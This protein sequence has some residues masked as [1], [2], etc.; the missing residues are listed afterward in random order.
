MM[1]MTQLLI[2]RDNTKY[3]NMISQLKGDI[4]SRDVLR[5][6]M[7]SALITK[8]TILGI[9]YLPFQGLFGWLAGGWLAGQPPHGS[10]FT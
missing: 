7:L 8:E 3:A 9:K 6:M 10:L 2:C 1:K 4:P 5:L